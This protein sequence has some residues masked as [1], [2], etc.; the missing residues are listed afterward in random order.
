MLLV[1]ATGIVTGTAEGFGLP[2]ICLAEPETAMYPSS[3]FRIE[4][5]TPDRVDTFADLNTLFGEAFEDMDTYTGQ[6]PDA[7]YLRG[8][9]A[10]DG[11]FALVAIEGD[12]VIGGLVAYTLRKFEQRRS[13]VYIYDLAVSAAYRRR[14]I[15]TALIRALQR[16]AAERGA[17]VIFVQ[18]DHGDDPAI[19]LYTEL[20][21]REEVLHF[22]I[23]ASAE[24]TEIAMQSFTV[25]PE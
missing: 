3:D 8:L 12:A 5:L 20:G 2:S 6:R 11:V 25:A 1:E 18:A 10:D 9:L 15:A 14:G 19:A 13:E 24:P 4:R 22:D 17:W 21:T 7:E 23:A 16:L